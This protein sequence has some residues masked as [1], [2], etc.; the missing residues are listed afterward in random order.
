MPA[1][2]LGKGYSSNRPYSLEMT[3]SS[4]HKINQME[5]EIVKDEQL[6]VKFCLEMNEI[7]GGHKQWKRRK[8]TK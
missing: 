8:R 3:Q 7:L 4:L 2:E 1:N 5:K 6:H